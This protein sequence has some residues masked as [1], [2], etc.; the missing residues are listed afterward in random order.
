MYQHEATKMIPT[1]ADISSKSAKKQI[2]DVFLLQLF[3]QYR[4]VLGGIWECFWTFKCERLK[5]PRGSFSIILFE[6]FPMKVEEHVQHLFKIVKEARVGVNKWFLSLQNHSRCCW[7][8]SFWIGL[9]WF[10]WKSCVCCN[11]E[12]RVQLGAPGSLDTVARPENLLSAWR[13]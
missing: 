2:S 13:S 3:V 6:N 9:N 10:W 8:L 7:N 11:L 12:S 5:C 1:N 4:L